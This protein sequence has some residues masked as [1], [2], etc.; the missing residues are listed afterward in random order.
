V[1][2]P[3][4][5]TNR[6]RPP[7]LTRHSSARLPCP[8][9]VCH[10]PRPVPPVPRAAGLPVP[11]AQPPSPGARSP[12]PGPARASAIS[13]IKAHIPWLA[14]VLAGPVLGLPPGRRWRFAPATHSWAQQG[15]QA[16]RRSGAYA[17]SSFL[18]LE[19]NKVPQALRRHRAT[20]VRGVGPL[21]RNNRS[22]LAALQRPCLSSAGGVRTSGPPRVPRS[23]PPG[24]TRRHRTPH[25]TAP[26]S[27]A[28]SAH[29]LSI[30]RCY[31]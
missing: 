15:S 20:N 2:W 29:E 25:S 17:W 16:L 19:R 9:G 13:A 22:R 8:K 7:R 21:R 4:T 18:P 23:V 31:Y 10:D 28:G 30:E 26:H 27:A 5:R 11:P 12:K 3:S 6:T 14:P 1:G 24:A